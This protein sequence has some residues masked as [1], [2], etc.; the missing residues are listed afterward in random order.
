MFFRCNSCVK[1]RLLH[2]K[3]TFLSN[4]QFF[5]WF[6]KSTLKVP[7]RSRTLGPLG[8]LQGTSP[9]RRV[10]AWKCKPVEE[11]DSSVD[12]KRTCQ[13]ICQTFNFKR[14][15]LFCGEECNDIINPK[16]SSRWRPYLVRAFVTVNNTPFKDFI[17]KNC[18]LRNDIWFKE[19]KFRVEPGVFDLHVADARYHQER[20]TN[21]LHSSYSDSLPK[22]SEKYLDNAHLCY[23]VYDCQ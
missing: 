4:H 7:W 8:D 12:K 18:L 17:L 15:C 9:G 21:F 19:V 20:K 5:C 11:K 1:Q 23:K 13:S 2:L 22:T 16:N 3:N 14:Y 10:P 6:P